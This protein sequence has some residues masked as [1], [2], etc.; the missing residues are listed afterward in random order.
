MKKKKRTVLICLF[1]L[2]ALLAIFKTGKRNPTIELDKD[3]KINI[4]EITECNNQTF[5]YDKRDNNTIYLICGNEIELKDDKKG[6]SLYKYL[7]QKDKKIGSFLDDLTARLESIYDEKDVEIYK[8]EGN[9]VSDDSFYLLKCNN[10][11]NKSTFFSKE[12]INEEQALTYCGVDKIEKEYSYTI[13]TKEKK[14]CQEKAKLYIKD[15]N[16]LIY[17]YCLD[18]IKIKEKGKLGVSLDKFYLQDESILESIIDNLESTSHLNDG[19]TTIFKD[20]SSKKFTKNGLTVIKCNTVKGNKDI[21]IG[22]ENMK[23][24]ENFCKK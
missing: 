6:L 10:K 4:R 12:E 3:Y 22:P 2:L 24:Q 15:T 18:E 17:T 11:E 16:R 20:T 7:D 23:F 21:Y 13:D 14:N 1:G 19:G 8:S 5:E 9:K